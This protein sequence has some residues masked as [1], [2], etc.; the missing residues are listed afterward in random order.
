[1]YDRLNTTYIPTRASI[2]ASL[3]WVLNIHDYA[4]C[5]YDAHTHFKNIVAREILC[6]Y[7]VNRNMEVNGA[8]G[9]G[10]AA[11]GDAMVTNISAS[12][13]LRS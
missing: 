7:G 9:G 3:F 2:Q 10:A 1:M 11:G 8:R 13:F 4:V 12:H 6:E 5:D